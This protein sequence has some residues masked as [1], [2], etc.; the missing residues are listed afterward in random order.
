MK[1]PMLSAIASAREG[2]RK[3]HGGPFGA[4]IVRQGKLIATAHNTVL[5]DRDPTCH[6][7]INAIRQACRKLKTHDLAGCALYTTAEPCPMCL[8][9][10]YW[11]RLSS[12]QI[13]VSMRVAARAGFDDAL[14]REELRRPPARRRIPTRTGI[15]AAACQSVFKEWKT[16]NGELY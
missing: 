6:A 11:A 7:E 16:L 15:M 5:R 9:A 14:I 8:S 4:C 1:H 10:I 13:G 2:I 3:G 12:L